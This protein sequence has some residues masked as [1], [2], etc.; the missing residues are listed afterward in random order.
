MSEKSNQFE[1]MIGR[2]HELVENQDADVKWNEKIP[3]PDNPKQPRQ[4]DI[5]IRKGN[6]LNLVEC[7]IHNKKQNVKWIEE[8]IGRRQSLNAH[9]VIAVSA[10]GFTSGAINKAV[11][12]GIIINDLL[13]LTK[14]EINSW[15]RAIAI[16]LFFYK[17]EKFEITL[18]FDKKD[19]ADLNNEIVEKELINYY[20]LQS[21]LNAAYDLIDSQK[22][23]VK[24]NKNKKVNFR[25]NGKI[26]GFLIQGKEVKE[27]EFLGKVSLEQIDLNVPITLAYGIPQSKVEARDVYIQN[28][29]LGQTS[30]MHN[31]GNV[32]ICLDLSKLEA[33]EFWQFRYTKTNGEHENY[34]KSFEIIEA[35]KVKMKLGKFKINLSV[36]AY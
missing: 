11:K 9:T 28:F 24:E 29:N 5:L 6:L 25:V 14:D 1:Q 18:F 17:F 10:S 36:S 21:I 30:I 7:R 4:V 12:Y 15:S 22:L 23:I 31:K 8:L 27:I 19:I 26:D 34:Y 13:G 33:P 20:G 32:C 16:S 35:E 3:D 2:I